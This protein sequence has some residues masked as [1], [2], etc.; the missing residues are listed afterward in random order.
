MTK[1][2]REAELLELMRAD[3][4]HMDL[5]AA[6]EAAGE[7]AQKQVAPK[8]MQAAPAEPKRERGRPTKAGRFLS[9]KSSKK[10]RKE[11]A[12]NK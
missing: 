9:S 11:E 7:L 3:R 6:R 2:N 12:S 5:H 4:P 10:Q 1:S 8:P